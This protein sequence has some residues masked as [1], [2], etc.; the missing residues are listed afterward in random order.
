MQQGKI[1]VEST[2]GIGSTFHFI[3]PYTKID[4]ETVAA[5][6]KRYDKLFSRREIKVLLV[7]DNLLSQKLAIKVLQNFNFL[8][9]LAE[10]GRRAIE[11]LAVNQYDII[12]MDLQMPE[13]DGYHASQIIR[14][15]L[16]L[17]TPIIAMTAH[18][19]VGEKNK[20]IA[21]G[22]NDYIAKPFVPENVFNKI[23][24]HT[25]LNQAQTELLAH[26]NADPFQLAPC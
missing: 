11:M 15:D 21:V 12:L 5:K 3:I 4:L 16:H 10:N 19:L 8:P 7:E 25:D 17:N 18:S 13:L 2:L 24:F 26:S 20:C 23:M 22:M 1:W 6:E 14:E 9:E